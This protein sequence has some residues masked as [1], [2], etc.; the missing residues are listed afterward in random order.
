MQSFSKG[1]KQLFENLKSTLTQSSDTA[2]YECDVIINEIRNKIGSVGIERQGAV[3][4]CLNQVLDKILPAFLKYTLNISEW[5]SSSDWEELETYLQLDYSQQGHFAEFRESL[6][7]ELN[8]FNKCMRQTESIRKR[9]L[10]RTYSL[11]NVID[12][13]RTFLPA[14]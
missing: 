2:D 12:H 10:R 9:L 1:E 4:Y 3:E 6:T 8:L 13:L 11:Q 14:K 7:Q 5:D